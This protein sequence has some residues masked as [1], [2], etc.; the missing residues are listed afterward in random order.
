MFSPDDTEGMQASIRSHGPLSASFDVYDDFENYVK[1]VYSKT[2]GAKLLGG[3]AIRVV[4]WGVDSA[5]GG[6]YWKVAN[7]WNPYW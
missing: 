3:H 2:A 4:G 6:A 1:G 7:S 5:G